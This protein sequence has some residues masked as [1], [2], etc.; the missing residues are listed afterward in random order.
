MDRIVITLN[1]DMT[2]VIEQDTS[3]NIIT[4]TVM[5]TGDDINFNDVVTEKRI[6]D[7][8]LLFDFIC[9]TA[10]EYVEA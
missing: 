9:E 3:G 2:Q 4:Y 5:G 10:E 7:K 1:N 6:L 8:G